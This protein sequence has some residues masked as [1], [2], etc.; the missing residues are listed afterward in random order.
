MKLDEM[1][2]HDMKI[3]GHAI[4][5]DAAMQLNVVRWHEIK[6][7]DMKLHDMNIKRDEHELEWSEMRWNEWDDIKFVKRNESTWK[8][9]L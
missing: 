5:R 7:T 1:A 9:K 2:W 8:L 4:K 6:L 3:K